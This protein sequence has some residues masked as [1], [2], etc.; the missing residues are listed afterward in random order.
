[1]GL[2]TKRGRTRERIA[3]VAR[4]ADTMREYEVRLGLATP[5]D[6]AGSI[7]KGLRTSFGVSQT[8]LAMAMDTTPTSIAYWE[9]GDR[10][11]TFIPLIQFLIAELRLLSIGGEQRDYDPTTGLLGRILACGVM[12]REEICNV[13]ESLATVMAVDPKLPEVGDGE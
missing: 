10:T 6:L 12:T 13:L 1:M 8:E 7:C 3:Q 4:D 2:G 5:G 11:P 9:A